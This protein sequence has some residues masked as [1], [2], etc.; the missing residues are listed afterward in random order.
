MKDLRSATA[1]P[2]DSVLGFGALFELF[3]GN[4]QAVLALLRAAT[5][6]I[7]SDVRRIEAA[8]LAGD[9]ATVAEATHRLKGTSGSI[10][11]KRLSAVVSSLEVASPHNSLGAKSPMILEL[12]AAVDTLSNAVAEFANFADSSAGTK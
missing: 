8:V 4:S 10:A 11:A 2:D 3:D 7:A 5:G 1:L 6:S 12:H 9:T